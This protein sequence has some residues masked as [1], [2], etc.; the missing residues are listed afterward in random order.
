MC[1]MIWEI[2]GLSGQLQFNWNVSKNVVWNHE[3][4][5]DFYVLQGSL[6]MLQVRDQWQGHNMNQSGAEHVGRRYMVLQSSF[7]NIWGRYHL[8]A[9]C[10]WFSFVWMRI[11]AWFI[12]NT[13]FNSK[14]S[15]NICNTMMLA[16]FKPEMLAL[17]WH[18]PIC[19]WNPQLGKMMVKKFEVL[20]Y[21]DDAN[22]WKM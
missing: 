22:T 4:A 11:G 2:A 17:A 10:K 12:D 16:H 7:L 5:M 13:W 21:Y 18:K 15:N 14:S 20:I 9:H 6:W 3:Y 1:E 19:C 8:Y